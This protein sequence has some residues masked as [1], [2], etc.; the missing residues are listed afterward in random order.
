MLY[1]S[2]Y[3][4]FSL[5]LG[6]QPLNASVT[7]SS[8][9]RTQPLASSQ[10]QL[11][12]EDTSTGAAV[13]AVSVTSLRSIVNNQSNCS[14]MRLAGNG[15]GGGGEGEHRIGRMEKAGSILS[16]TSQVHKTHEK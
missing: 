9:G 16:L 11:S 3:I 15:G 13:S 1:L 5:S 12:A 2:P 4:F 7:T 6:P 14:L 10:K 8:D